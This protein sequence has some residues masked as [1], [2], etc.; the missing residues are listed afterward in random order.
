LI[1]YVVAVV[2]DR[3]KDPIACRADWFAEEANGQDSERE[4]H[5]ALPARVRPF[6]AIIAGKADAN[7]QTALGTIL[8]IR[9]LGQAVSA[10]PT[11]LESS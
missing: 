11:R 9:D 6:E 5:K 4:T 2:V 3:A 1:T 10:A 7:C 8:G